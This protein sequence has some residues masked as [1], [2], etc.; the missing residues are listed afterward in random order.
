MQR[1]L[2]RRC[3]RCWQYKLCARRFIEKN[4]P[5]QA[6]AF[7]A[8]FAKLDYGYQVRGIDPLAT[9]G[10]VE[11]KKRQLPDVPSEIACDGGDPI[12]LPARLHPWVQYVTPSAAEHPSTTAP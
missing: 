4:Y 1:A 7:A 11:I 9:S 8:L 3:A 10:R 12:V 2:E 6:P 5:D